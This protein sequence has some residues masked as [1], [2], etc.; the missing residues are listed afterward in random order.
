MDKFEHYL[1]QVC[2]SVGGSKS[3]RQHI[4]QELR[5]HLRD[6]AAEHRAA[7]LSEE[8]ALTR[9]LAD[10]GGPE[11]VRSELEATH[12]H[13]LMAV[14]VDKA[15]QW[16][17]TTMKAK[18]LWTTWAY[19]TTAGVVALELL[20]SWYVVTFEVP[21]MQKL[22]ADGII[23]LYGEAGDPAITWMFSFLSGLQWTWHTLACW[24]ALALAALWGLFEWR[25]R[26]ENKPFMRL[27]AL[28]TLALGMTVVSV[29]TAGSMELPFFLQLP[30]MGQVSAS[31]AIRRMATIDAS[32]GALE[33]AMDKKDWDA[34]QKEADRA[35]KA[36]KSLSAAAGW[37]NE[38]TPPEEQPTVDLFQARLK[39]ASESLAAAQEAIRGKDTERLQAALRKFHEVYGAVG[40]LAR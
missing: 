25:V 7:G 40:R 13:R 39:E 6:A 5:E 28:G 4:R 10:F 21:K 15:M 24:V 27:A 1:D 33:Q 18:W 19:L 36:I 22:K 32:V 35:T 2:R 34:A 26:G 30:M 23:R 9:A 3:L 37:F 38:T 17:E 20:F 8:E 16:K 29:I 11:Q 14:V 31:S 12:G